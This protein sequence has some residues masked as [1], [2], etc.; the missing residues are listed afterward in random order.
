MLYLVLIGV[1]VFATLGICLLW[2][3]AADQHS[4]R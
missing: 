4:G 2:V 3:D 1:F